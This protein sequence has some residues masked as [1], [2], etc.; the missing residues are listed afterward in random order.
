MRN[1]LIISV[2]IALSLLVTAFIVSR[3]KTDPIDPPGIA[4]LEKVTLGDMEQWILIRSRDS[5]NPV[6]LWLHGGPGSSQ[7]PIARH[8]NGELE[9]DFTVVHWDQR[10]AGRSNPRNFDES[11]M[12]IEQFVSDAHELTQILK[13]RFGKEKIFILGHSWGT[14]IGIELA[15]LYPEDYHAYIAVSQVT[16]PYREQQLAYEWLKD[17]IELRGKKNDLRDFEKLGEPPFEEHERYVALAKMVDSFGGGMDIGMLKLAS[18]AIGAPE[19]RLRDYV[20]WLR[21]SSRGSGPM[22]ESTLELNVFEDFP[23]I[24]IPVYFFSGR[25]DHN[26]PLQLV[27]E[28]YEK[29]KAP[30]GKSFIIFEQSA[31]APFIGEPDIFNEKIRQI[32]SELLDSH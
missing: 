28:Y 31:H 25:R 23:E 26:T 16:D 13:E 10:G 2:F 27:E 30:A 19:Y 1:L 14:R 24:D 4:S 9:W 15:T 11:T 7:M 32:K 3:G 29:V 6:L 5:S 21:G 20:S 18:I 22:W 12:T 17:E 8:F